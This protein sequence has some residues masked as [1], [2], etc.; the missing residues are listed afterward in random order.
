MSQ[1]AKINDFHGAIQLAEFGFNPTDLHGERY[2]Q[3]QSSGLQMHG[4]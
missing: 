2:P 3:G 4:W 1:F